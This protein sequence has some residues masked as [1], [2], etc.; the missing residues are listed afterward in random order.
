[1]ISE[2]GYIVTNNHVIRSASEIEITLNNKKYQA[3]LIELIQRWI[4]LLKI[5]A[6]ENYHIP[7]LPI[8]ML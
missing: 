4:L 6:N 2:D 8:Q 1:M 5:D 3:K 7:L